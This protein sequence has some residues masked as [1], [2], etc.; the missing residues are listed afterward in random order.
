MK[1]SKSSRTFVVH[2]WNVKVRFATYWGGEEQ[3]GSFLEWTTGIW[4][5]WKAELSSPWGVSEKPS[6]SAKATLL[7]QK[8]GA[9]EWDWMNWQIHPF[10]RRGNWKGIW[11][12]EE[13][14]R[15]QI[16]F[17]VSFKSGKT[18]ATRR[19]R[20]NLFRVKLKRSLQEIA[21]GLN[22]SPKGIIFFHPL[23]Y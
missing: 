15:G 12:G 3:L 11:G 5:S 19:A 20:G 1:L 23:K 21:V 18:L 10:Y 4:W 22:R 8:V 16:K 13:K 14:R 6:E 7:V 17:Q 2:R 9:W